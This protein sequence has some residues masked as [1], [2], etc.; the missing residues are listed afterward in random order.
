[1]T[2]WSNLG[3]A[4]AEMVEA[5]AQ[6]GIRSDRV[7]EAMGTIPRHLFVGR[8]R[9][10]EAY[11]DRPLPIGF[12]QTI[13]QPYIVAL[14]LDALALSGTERVL[15]VGTGSGYQAALLGL[16]A[17]EVVT[18]ETIPEL[19]ERARD[20]LARLGLDNVRAVLGD[21]S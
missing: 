3:A 8:D 10:D 18:I 13:S 12:G 14:T 4:R 9:R 7:L 20:L 17:R 21:G 11:A 16:I 6:R 1:M 19:H 2:A 5:L 15:D